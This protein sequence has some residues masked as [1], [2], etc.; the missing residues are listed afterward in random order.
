[1]LSL[2]VWGRL[3]SAL[4][5][6]CGMAIFFYVN[7]AIV[8]F[9]IDAV[10]AKSQGRKIKTGIKVMFIIAMVLLAIMIAL[11]IYVFVLLLRLSIYGPF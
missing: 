7:A 11:G 9:I 1:M 10:K 5:Y 3:F 4:G 6:A 2:D 8:L